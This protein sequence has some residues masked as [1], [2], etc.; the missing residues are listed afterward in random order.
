MSVQINPAQQ[1][2]QEGDNFRVGQIVECWRQENGA[3]EIAEIVSY[4]VDAR[5]RRA[6]RYTV[7]WQDN[8]SDSTSVSI[9]DRLILSLTAD[10]TPNPLQ[11]E[12]EWIICNHCESICALIIVHA[13]IYK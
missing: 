13:H 4:N 8:D 9:P 12:G 11:E 1:L 7:N 5:N 6:Y 3:W 10:L 2:L